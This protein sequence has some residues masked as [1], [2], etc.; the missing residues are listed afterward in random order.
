MLESIEQQKEKGLFEVLFVDNGSND[1][2][3]ALIHSFIDGHPELDC[4][5]LVYVEKKSSY[6]AR[7]FGVEHAKGD[8]FA[9]TDADCIL[10]DDYIQNIVNVF[11]SLE[12]Q[13]LI[14]SGNIELMVENPRNIWEN[15][16]QS[17]FLQNKSSHLVNKVATANMV[18]SKET[19]FQVGYFL[20]VRSTGDSE[21]SQRSVQKGNKIEFHPDIL[22][23]HPTRKTFGEINKKFSRLG[24]GKGQRWK[25]GKWLLIILYTLKIF[26][27]KT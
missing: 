22:V 25:K 23:Y 12:S 2:T 1:G 21:W 3:S 15:F 18:V 16:D 11:S 8:I 17:S 7:N 5:V 9:F 14:L 20:E 4:R 13:N 27:Y 26:N 24:F 10:R 6:A 19:F